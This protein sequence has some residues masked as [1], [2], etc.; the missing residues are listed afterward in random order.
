MPRGKTLIKV[1][2]VKRLSDT[3]TYGGIASEKLFTVPPGAD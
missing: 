2:W 1:P 3:L